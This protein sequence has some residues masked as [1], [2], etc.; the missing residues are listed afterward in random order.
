MQ[1]GEGDIGNWQALNR[2]SLVC[3]DVG[4]NSTD[5]CS[6]DL[7]SAVNGTRCDARVRE[8]AYSLETSFAFQ[9]PS[10]DGGGCHGWESSH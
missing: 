7:A 4:S 2:L 8:L 1:S 9:G 5:L 10:L 6:V 3:R